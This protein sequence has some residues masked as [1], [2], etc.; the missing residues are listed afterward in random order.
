MCSGLKFC[1][2]FT[3]FGLGSCGGSPHTSGATG[4][5]GPVPA[6]DHVVL[7]VL[8]NHSFSD[9]IGSS[10]MPYFNS[11]ASQHSLAANYFADAHVS[12]SDYFLLSTGMEE[13][14][15]NNFAGT[16]S[17]DNIARALTAAGKSWHAYMES[18]PS[19]GYT[20]GDV[21]PYLKHHDPF[22]YLQDVLSSAQQSSNVVPFSQMA[23]DLASGTLPAF[24]FVVPNAENDAH[25]CPGQEPT[26]PDSG[27]LQKTDDWLRTNIDPIISSPAFG[28]GVLIITW[29]EGNI[30]DTAN[31]GGQ[32]ATVIVGSHVKTGFQSMTFF[33]HES[34]LRLIMDLLQ[35]ADHPGASATAPSMAEFFQ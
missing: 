30:N 31:G 22:V 1:L 29:D 4:S 17:D 19:A 23:T 6:A 34:T 8:E 2:L 11:L 24:S 33:Q 15:D 16:V 28:N 14:N 25:S 9:V 5:P 21:F 32:V 18:I 7:V 13:T 10:S 20:G 27:K 26:C 12:L 35:V 3:V